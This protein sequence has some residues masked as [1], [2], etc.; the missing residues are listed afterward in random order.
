MVKMNFMEM[1]PATVFKEYNYTYVNNHLNEN[2]VI[3]KKMNTSNEKYKFKL[4]Y[5]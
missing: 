1:I 3:Y 4:F 2:F 5:L